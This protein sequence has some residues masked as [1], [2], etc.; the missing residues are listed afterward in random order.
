MNRKEHKGEKHYLAY[1]CV[2]TD[3]VTGLRLILCL[4]VPFFEYL[5]ESSIGIPK[6]WGG[7][8]RFEHIT[9][10]CL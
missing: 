6:S 8:W 3:C 5:Q 7:I 4:A 2:A 10:L 1:I 9:A